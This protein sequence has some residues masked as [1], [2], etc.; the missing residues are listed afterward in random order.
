[1]YKNKPFEFRCTYR[2]FCLPLIGLSKFLQNNSRFIFPDK[3]L[4]YDLIVKKYV[5]LDCSHFSDENDFIMFKNTNNLYV[6]IYDIV[7][8]YCENSVI[9]LM[10]VFNLFKNKF[11]LIGI[12]ILSKNYSISA[13]SIKYF[14]KNFNSVNRSLH[15]SYEL[16][17]RNAYFGG[18]CEVFGNKNN[19]ENIYY[20]D[21]P[22]M[23]SSCMVENYPTGIISF[24]HPLEIKK[25]GFY[26][27]NYTSNMDI[28]ILPQ[29]Y[30]KLYFA[31]G[32]FIGTFWFEE[33]LLFMENGGIV[34]EIYS[35][36]TYSEYKPIFLDFI[37]TVEEF[38]K[39]CPITKHI[40]KNI[41]N[42]LYG[43]FG[44]GHIGTK[45]ILSANN[46]IGHDYIKFDDFFVINS[47]I[48]INTARNVAI[49]AV[50]SSKAR[51][52][53]WNGFLSIQNFGGRILYS[54]TDSI[55]AAFDKGIN[56]IDK[57]IGNI[58]FNSNNINTYVIDAVFSS[59]KSY[60][61]RYANI[62]IIKIKGVNTKSVTFDQFK[63]SFYNKIELVFHDQIMLNRVNYNINIKVVKKVINL[64]TYKKRIFSDCLNY[65]NP[66]RFHS[67]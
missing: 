61:V 18:R 6:N 12:N 53:L 40:G 30:D 36:L 64:N 22:G 14:I 45:T 55:F 51:I 4:T 33:I 57:H 28:P 39:L 19:N 2:I 1:V 60:A 46:P 17:I 20:F 47:T 37:N 43:R 8:K 29:K 34:N 25:P 63:N 32:T 67:I 21:F 49:S 31:N 7:L 35:A 44:M 66:I 5:Y 52:K 13:L 24:D 9:T 65:S 16:Y 11:S 10:E 42:S 15:L 59:S 58:Y 27:I 48:N 41:I 62:S 56:P 50:T 23:Y 38:K 26:C 3:A 54:D